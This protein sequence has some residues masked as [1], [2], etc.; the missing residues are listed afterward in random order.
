MLFLKQI[1]KLQIEGNV[2]LLGHHKN[3]AAWWRKSDVVQINCHACVCLDRFRLARETAKKQQ[4]AGKVNQ[5]EKEKLA[6][7][8]RSI[9]CWFVLL[10]IFKRSVR[11]FVKLSE[12]CLPRQGHLNIHV[13]LFDR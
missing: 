2:Q 7:Q 6:F 10:C 4:T 12:V 13:H 8:G 5:G 1:H 11:L 9:G 3:G